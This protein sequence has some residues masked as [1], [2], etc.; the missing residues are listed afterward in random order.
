MLIVLFVA[1]TA[2][3]VGGAL[4]Y[5][6]H[7]RRHGA[8]RFF[9]SGSDLGP[10]GG[11]DSPPGLGP[12]PPPPSGAAHPE[13]GLW[14]RGMS[15]VHDVRDVPMAYYLDDKMTER[16]TSTEPWMIGDGK[17]T[18]GHSEGRPTKTDDVVGERAPEGAKGGGALGRAWSKRGSRRLE[19][20]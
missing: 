17:K 15:S 2:I 16:G 4:L 20:K 19:K 1:F 3:G 13:L 14:A 6:R 5:R 9:G 10:L 11:R 12:N 18:A 7:K 8:E